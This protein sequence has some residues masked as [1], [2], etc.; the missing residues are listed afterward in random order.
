[1]ANIN[2]LR[3]SNRLKEIFQSAVDMSDC[4]DAD[5]DNGKY[6][7]RALAALALNMK[8][9]LDYDS[10]AKHITDGYHDMGI[11]AIYLDAV[12]K[13]L[14]LVQSKWKKE[15]TGG[16]SQ[17]EMQT[18]V[19]G[20]KR[21][22]N[23]DLDGANQKIMNKQND[24]EFA[25][26]QMGYQIQ[27]LYIHTGN[28]E[29]DVYAKRPMTE[30]IS[31]VNDDVNTLLVYEE[32][33]FKKIYEYLAKGQNPQEINIDDVILT[34]WGKIEEPYVCYYGLISAAAIGE[35]YQENGNELFAKNIRYYKGSTE[36]NE[37]MKKVLLQ[38][39]ENFVYY[40]NG[41][42]LLCESVERKAKGSTTNATG[43]FSLKGVSLVNGAQTTGTIGNVYCENM[44]QL[45]KAS[46]MVQIIDISKAGEKIARQITKLSNTQNK[47]ENKDFA[48]L[49]PQQERIRTELLFS[50]IIYL[51]KSGDVITDAEYQI[52]FDEAIVALACCDELSYA[53]LTKRN[54]GAL[55]EDTS[56]A[57]YKALI[58]PS[59]NSFKIIN[60]VRVIRKI[61]QLLQEKKEVL[62]GKE[63]LVCIHGN[64]FIEYCY[65]RLF[66][67]KDGFLSRVMDMDTFG[68]EIETTL[69]EKIS[70]ISDVLN[71]LYVD[72][73]PANVFKNT[74]K[75]R[76]IY[77]EIIK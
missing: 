34:N 9:E 63:R 8:C 15:G 10:S 50:H 12:Q 48:A 41:I 45:S 76:N 32:I 22:L 68:E 13:K 66:I 51:Y 11:D 60:G 67:S 54:V 1:M 44:E 74:S 46:V 30:L 7:T 65:L 16:I 25:L 24:I 43:L 2:I 35:W 40:N 75:C 29:A 21:I 42:K 71:E 73:Y 57:P 17:E 55:S 6:E 38:E 62:T 53:T 39:P 28:Q 69:G 49:D 59:T 31:N 37:G 4:K 72:S 58:N 20:I 23:I 18:F 33:S 19:E 36:V 56:K 70:K 47:I 5:V 64:R 77:E 3:T 61:E 52:S 26:T 14:F 27:L